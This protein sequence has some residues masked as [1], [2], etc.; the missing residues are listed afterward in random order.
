AATFGA[1]AKGNTIG[2]TGGAGGDDSSVGVGVGGADGGVGMIGDPCEPDGGCE[3][4]VCTKVGN[5]KYCTT[6]C[7]PGC[8]LGTY[9]S[10]IEG[11]PICVPDLNQECL[12]CIG[13]IDCKMPSDTCLTAPLGDKFC[14]RDCTTLGDCPPGFQCISG[15]EYPP[16]DGG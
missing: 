11:K 15:N 16:M 12:K 3:K 5:G 1:C 14:A 6:P 4:G 2:E 9:C 10:I 7:P 13:A 8:P